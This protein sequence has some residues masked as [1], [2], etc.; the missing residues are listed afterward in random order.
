MGKMR[1]IALIEEL[2][3]TSLHDRKDHHPHPKHELAS[4]DNY[5]SS[6][7]ENILSRY[8]IYSMTTLV[9]EQEDIERSAQPDGQHHM[10]KESTNNKHEKA[11]PRG[12]RASVIINT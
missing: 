8:G 9:F 7:D 12:S 6:C 3:L 5:K 1:V 4:G 11:V 2:R 10:C